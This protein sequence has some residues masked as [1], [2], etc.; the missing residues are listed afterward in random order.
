MDYVLFLF[1]LTGLLPLTPP[2]YEESTA[3]SPVF[4]LLDPIFCPRATA[5]DHPSPH[6]GQYPDNKRLP[7]PQLYK[8]NAAMATCCQR[9]YPAKRRRPRTI[10]SSRPLP[11]GPPPPPPARWR[12]GGLFKSR[13]SWA[14]PER[15]A[16]CNPMAAL[17]GL[18][19]RHPDPRRRRTALCR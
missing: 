2:A 9:P 17:E 6:P 16:S 15:P 18:G 5:S 11:D 10:P 14:A 8:Y 3:L 13:I 4:L 19:R 7:F 1:I 12:R